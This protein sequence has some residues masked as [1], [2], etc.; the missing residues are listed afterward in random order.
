MNN[1]PTLSP[2]VR[3]VMSNNPHTCLYFCRARVAKLLS[4]EC[5]FLQKGKEVRLGKGTYGRV[6]RVSYKGK[7][8]ALKLAA[9]GSKVVFEHEMEMLRRLQGAGGAPMA[10]AYSEDPS[11]LLMTYLG[12]ECLADVLSAQ[13]SQKQ[14]LQLSVKLAEAVAAVHAAGIVHCDLKPTNVMVQLRGAAGAPSV[15]I[16][17]FGM[18]LPVG[19]CHPESSKGRQSWYCACVHQGTPLTE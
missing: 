1:Y 10:L 13:R 12:K 15:H 3:K 14:L 19:Q 8:C 5:K 18:A 17:D 6:V 11:C 7:E 16:I 9:P 2:N 4:K